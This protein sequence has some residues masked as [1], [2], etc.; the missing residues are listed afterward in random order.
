VTRNRLAAVGEEA[1]L[2]PSLTRGAAVFIFEE[3]KRGAWTWQFGA[4][5]DQARIEPEGLAARRDREL[6]GSLGA[7]WKWSEADALAFTV[8]QTGRAP[9]AQESFAYGPHA[10]TQAFEVGDPALAAEKSLGLELS[11]RRRTGVVTG[12]LTVF[13]NRFR[14]FIFE[15]PSGLV[16]VE[17]DGGFE[18]LAAGTGSSDS[19]PVLN[20]IQ[21]DANFWGMEV[22]A[23]WHLPTVGASQFDLKLGGDFTRAREGARHLPRIPAARVI[24]GFE[25]AQGPWAAGIDCQFV[26]DQERVA[27]NETASEGYAAIGAQ[28]SWTMV[29]GR[30]NYE[31]FVRGTNLANEEMRSHSSFLKEL[32]PLGGRAVTSGVRLRF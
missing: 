28:A 22:E 7:I 2:P 30:V 12:E 26:F 27:A 5:V 17:H 25:W 23:T 14:N 24:T 1:F 15:Q 20:Y 19:L 3:T 32:A 10:G 13:N 8:A 16:A 18:F 6:S 21:R 11:Y 9:N 4:R 31:L 29:R